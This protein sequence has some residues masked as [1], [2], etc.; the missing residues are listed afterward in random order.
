M[1]P[2]HYCYCSSSSSEVA[3]ASH[4]TKCRAIKAAFYVVKIDA[5]SRS[6]ADEEVDRALRSSR[7]VSIVQAMQ[8]PDL[9]T[10]CHNHLQASF[11][12]QC[13]TVSS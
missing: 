1:W 6:C 10:N 3:F 4:V 5:R 13:A 7:T 2:Q 11:T 8:R 9:L 12:L